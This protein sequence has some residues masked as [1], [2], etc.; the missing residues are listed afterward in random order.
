M[1]HTCSAITFSVPSK[2]HYNCFYYKANSFTSDL[3]NH[4]FREMSLFSL[5]NIGEYVYC[6][7]KSHNSSLKVVF[8]L[9]CFLTLLYSVHD[10][11]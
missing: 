11:F 8:L 7:I 3:L 2:Q 1:I 9:F 6:T 4:L 5:H 10:I